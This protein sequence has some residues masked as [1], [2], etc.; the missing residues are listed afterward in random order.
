MKVDILQY[1]DANKEDE[2]WDP[3]WDVQT[4]ML[5]DGWSAEIR[6]PFRIAPYNV[7]LLK[8]TY[9]WSV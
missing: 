4:N 2:S 1:D 7:F 6:V 9:F 5:P 3:V 8:I